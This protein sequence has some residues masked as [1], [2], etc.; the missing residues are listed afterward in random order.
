MPSLHKVDGP[1]SP[2]LANHACYLKLSRPRSRINLNPG[3]LLHTNRIDEEL[4][5]KHTHSINKFSL[6]T[7]LF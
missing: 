7:D 4:L 5:V 2:E 1:A 3:G 6:A